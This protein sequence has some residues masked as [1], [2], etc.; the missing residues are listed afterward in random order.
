MKGIDNPLPQDFVRQIKSAWPSFRDYANTPGVPLDE[1]TQAYHRP[2]SLQ[3]KWFFIP[4]PIMDQTVSVVDHL[5]D[6]IS[7]V[8]V[9]NKAFP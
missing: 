2:K 9:Y 4:W 8:V 7:R 6:A 5:I 1:K 3:G